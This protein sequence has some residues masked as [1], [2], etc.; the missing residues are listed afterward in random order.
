VRSRIKIWSGLL[1]LGWSWLVI[2]PLTVLGFLGTVRDQIIVPEKPILYTVAYWLPD[3]SWSTYLILIMCLWLLCILESS[4]RT[5]TKRDKEIYDLKSPKIRILFNE[6]EERSVSPLDS[7][8][9]YWKI[10]IENTSVT[11]IEECLLEIRYNG[12]GPHTV[13]RP[14][15]IRPLDIETCCFIASS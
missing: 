8:K 15:D 14:F 7:G 4:F 1:K 9:N 10:Y 11:R 13:L 6:N 12:H 3:W 2:G 5:I